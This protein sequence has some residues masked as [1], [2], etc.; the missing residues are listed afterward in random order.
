MR[1]D[2]A[3][4]IIA[5]VILLAIAVAT[6]TP[7]NGPPVTGSQWCIACGELGALDVIANVVLFLPFGFAL[8][9]ATNGR[10]AVFVC[11]VTTVVVEAMQVRIVP[12]R[13]AS[14]GDVVAN[15]LGGLL[16]A[17]LAI[18]GARLL[19]PTRRT[20]TG[21]ALGWCAVFGAI[22]AA[23]AWGL[24]QAPVA[25][26]LWIQWRP[27]RAGYEPFTGRLLSF[28]VDGI[29]LPT[30][31]PAPVFGLAHE[32]MS[33]EWHATVRIDRDGLT[34]G[35]AVLVRVSEEY[36]LPLMI[37]QFGWDLTC[38]RRVRSA[39][40]RFRSPRFA[41]H[42]ALRMKS[43]V[44]HPDIVQLRCA[45]RGTTMVLSSQAGSARDEQVMRLSP[46]LG[47]ALLSPFDVP[48]S[49]RTTW[50]GSLWL[51]A[52]AFPIGYWWSASLSGATRAQRRRHSAFVVVAF[53]VGATSGLVLAPLAAH[54]AVAAW[55][56]WLSAGLGVVAGGL[57]AR[58]VRPFLLP[59]S[60][61]TSA[62]VAAPAFD[63]LR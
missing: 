15:S 38:V 5:G 60:R 25:R 24:T 17:Q 39:T 43:G 62:E 37:E 7:S 27:E 42:S 11:F 34:L 14:L 16:G 33:E 63:P 21:L 61:T 47:W 45:R 49:G 2:R 28:E 32:L 48:L 50:L 18:H 6:L 23:T 9:R 54:T 1:L 51:I 20:A 13:D 10:V 29:D 40:L 46:S 3:W 22:G 8:T 56:E 53:A 59:R 36:A 19:G 55:W 35:R 30:G 26:S 44:H 12:G 58:L 57:T 4:G 41:L 52:I 31:Y